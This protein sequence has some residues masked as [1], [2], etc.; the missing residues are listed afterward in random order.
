MSKELL[1]RIHVFDALKLCQG[2]RVGEQIICDK[3]LSEEA[4]LLITSS[5]KRNSLLIDQINK[6]KQ[7]KQGIE[8]ILVIL[9]FSNY[10]NN[11]SKMINLPKEGFKLFV[12]KV[13]RD[14]NGFNHDS[15]ATVEI[16]VRDFLKSNSM[17]KEN[18]LYYINKRFYPLIKDRVFFGLDEEKDNRVTIA[19][20]YAY[21]GLVCS[22]CF[23]VPNIR[24][25]EDEIVVVKDKVNTNNYVNKCITM[26]SKESVYE[27]VK[28]IKD[29]YKN[30][31]KNKISENKVKYN[32]DLLMSFKDNYEKIEDEKLVTLLKE[33]F[34]IDFSSFSVKEN[35]NCLLNKYSESYD[36]DIKWYRIEAHNFPMEINF[37]D[38]EGL[39]SKEFRDELVQKLNVDGYKDS[40]SFQIRLPFIKGMVH[41]CDIKKFYARHNVETINGIDVSK[42][43]M[44]LTESQFKAI[45]YINDNKKV[46]HFKNINDYIRKI[47]EYD[48]AFGVV[49]ADGK[50]EEYVDLEYQ[51]VLT[52]PLFE[53][54]DDK[55]LF[56][57]IKESYEL[58]K[59]KCKFN[60]IK[61]KIFFEADKGEEISLG[62]KIVIEKNEAFYKRTNTFDTRR[63]NIF[64]Q[65]KRNALICRLPVKGTRKYL[66]SDLLELLYHA[67][68]IKMDRRDFLG[69]YEIYGS[70]FDYEY[71]DSVLLRSP[72][73][74][75]NEIVYSSNRY[76]KN[77]E[78]EEFFSHLKGTVMVNPKGYFPDRLG[79]A[80]YDGDSVCII[81]DARIVKKVRNY[82]EKYPLCKI[83]SIKANSVE[84]SFYN[85]MICCQNT[86]SSRVGILSNKGLIDAAIIYMEDNIEDKNE[87][88]TYTILNGLEIDSA[89][90]GKKPYL[91]DVLNKKN[92][93]E[94][95]VNLYESFLKG[96]K[97]LEDENKIKT[98][99]ELTKETP[100]ANNN[101][102]SSLCFVN[103]N[104][105]YESNK[106]KR[107]EKIIIDSFLKAEIIAINKAYYRCSNLVRHTFSL[108]AKKRRE[109]K[110]IKAQTLGEEILKKKESK[111]N[112][113]DIV[114]SV[115][116]N[117]SEAYKKIKAYI[118]SKDKFHFL[119]SLEQRK[120]YLLEEMELEIN[121]EE[122]F[123]ELINFKND[124]YRLLFCALC[125]IRDNITSISLCDDEK[126]DYE[127]SS[128]EIKMHY[129][130][131]KEEIEN[132]VIDRIND[133]IPSSLSQKEFNAL[134]IKY[135]KE[136]ASK[137]SF[138]DIK[139]AIDIYNSKSIF[140]IFIDQV[141]DNIEK[142]VVA[143]DEKN[144]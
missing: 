126:Q 3:E 94:R 62:E 45:K 72:H 95:L 97:E 107:K 108:N 66:S 142:E 24:F 61:E 123:N 55:L 77:D 84:N 87:V 127:F 139:E 110:R 134:I 80:D 20:L 136:E 111:F 115:G 26:I 63:K 105:K 71:S 69:T 22:D 57:L 58:T 10:I 23:V 76:M 131:I 102:I 100:E 81:K 7:K 48:Y 121:D 79:G 15:D 99:K 27:S 122:V 116:I 9:D 34:Q 25:N 112:F 19:K 114:D 89:K 14:N 124:G 60:N 32:I 36:K 68:N 120:K 96:K 65:R 82:P 40:N 2:Q 6:I 73:Y 28:K 103:E 128:Q 104:Y 140:T 106:V 141:K 53:N 130:K 4:R 47:N 17:S 52:L 125:Y 42:I 21:S 35:L 16:E 67:G 92:D 117:N 137:Y 132:K 33:F 30:K 109:G 143:N 98:L 70:S 91:D 50:A 75:K 29:E 46:I 1:Y 39:I 133:G 43:K 138:N 135:L 59:E 86:F 8:E 64:D 113:D 93:D 38:G 13:E 18:R 118:N 31:D 101:I 49:S 83:S 88:C 56:D 144:H 129:K 41:S 74:A 54:R 78:R 51:F 85:R 44:I 90:N 5:D 37:F 12:H 11:K 119:T